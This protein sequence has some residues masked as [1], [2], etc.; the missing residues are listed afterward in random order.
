MLL[1]LGIG[2]RLECSASSVLDITMNIQRSNLLIAQYKVIEDYL[3]L[4]PGLPHL[5]V[6]DIL[7]KLHGKT[8]N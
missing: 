8:W 3:A 2:W 6:E 5:C 4:I 1:L 7:E